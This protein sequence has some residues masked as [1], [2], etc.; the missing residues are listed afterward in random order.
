MTHHRT[1][2][3]EQTW[4]TRFYEFGGYDCMSAGTTVVCQATDV[5]NEDQYDVVT[6]DHADS[7]YRVDGLNRHDS[8]P[9][10]AEVATFIAAAPDLYR[11]L[12]ALVDWV[13]DSEAVEFADA[14]SALRK[15]R[16]ER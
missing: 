1:K 6:V 12:Y 4:F 9:I 7:G 3:W 2:P 13:G 15:S 8:S 11:A 10:A 16:G 14:L 5:G